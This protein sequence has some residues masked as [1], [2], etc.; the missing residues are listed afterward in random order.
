MIKLFDNNGRETR[1]PF[2]IS[3]RSD[4]SDRSFPLNDLDPVSREYIYIYYI[5]LICMIYS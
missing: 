3:G 1:E 5:L 2:H 4:R